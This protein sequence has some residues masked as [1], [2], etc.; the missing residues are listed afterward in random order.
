MEIPRGSGMAKAKVLKEKYGAKLEFPEG[1]GCKPRKPS[2]RQ[3]V[4]IFCNHKNDALCFHFFQLGPNVSVGSNV[5]IG[6]GARVRETILLD[7][8]ELKVMSV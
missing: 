3:G 6:A 2:M 8:A 7:G 5:V 4:G 1:W